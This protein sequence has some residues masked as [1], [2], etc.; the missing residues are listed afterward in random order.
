[1]G[2]LKQYSTFI[3]NQ[4][5]ET[6]IVDR[7][8]NTVV[9]TVIKTSADQI[10]LQGTLQSGALLSYH[11]RGGKPF[12]SAPKFLWRIY[13]DK[14]EIE[15]TASSAGLNVGYGD[16]QILVHDQ[17]TGNV[18]KVE[19]EKDEWDELGVTARNVARLYE[20]FRNGET[21]G[22]ASFE[23]AVKHHELIDG[24]Y[25]HWDADDQGRLA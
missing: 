16:E 11:L 13:G 24:M 20:A 18:E 1:L 6:R 8:T 23:E 14:G 2:P 10:L 25:N 5:P 21:D 12:P 22:V 7:A 4:R 15:L 3:G 17:A 9:D 19:V